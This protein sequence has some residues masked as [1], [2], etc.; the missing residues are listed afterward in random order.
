MNNSIKKNSILSFFNNNINKFKNKKI[1]K[2]KE[3]FYKCVNDRFLEILKKSIKENDLKES[4]LDNFY[5]KNS[6]FVNSSNNF[7]KSENINELNKPSISVENYKYLINKE[8]LVPSSIIVFDKNPL[9][10][11]GKFSKN[12]PYVRIVIYDENRNIIF[13]KEIGSSKK[14]EKIFI[15]NKKDIDKKYLISETGKYHV[16]YFTML[17]KNDIEII[18]C[19][20]YSKA[21]I[22]NVYLKD[23]KLWADLGPLGQCLLNQIEK[24]L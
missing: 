15:I 16:Y 8:V 22:R 23:D 19:I 1:N 24:F 11:S 12:S 20:Q 18:P 7:N 6:L 9:I 5:K 13:S 17:A 4:N 2:K 21:V 3:Y 14:G 10:I